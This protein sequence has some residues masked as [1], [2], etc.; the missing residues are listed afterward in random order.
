MVLYANTFFQIISLF[1]ISLIGVMFLVKKK[2]ES[3][4]NHIFKNL[5]I[6]G[7]LSIIL[8]IASIVCAFRDPNAFVSM[9]FGKAYL[10]T[11]IAF[12]LLYSIYAIIVTNG[13]ATNEQK[14]ESYKKHKSLFITIFCLIAVA[15][16]IAPIYTYVDSPKVMYTYGPATILT[17]IIVG[18]NIVLW[19]SLLI[20]RFRKIAPRKTFP[21]VQV[22]VLGGISTLVQLSHPEILLL[23]AAMVFSIVIMYFSVFTIENPDLE[24]I[25]EI[26]NARNAAVKASQAKTDFLS[27]MSHELRTPLNAI[28]GFSQGLMEQDLPKDAEEDVEDIINASESLLELVNE[29]LDISK[30][31]SNKFELVNVDY[32]VRKAYKYL[33]TMTEGRI[34]DKEIEFIHK[35]DESIPPVLY[36]DCVRI[37]QIAINLLTNSVKYTKAGYVKLNMN[38]EKIDDVS[39]YLVVTVSDSGIGIKEEDM[40][41]LF[42]KFSRLDTKKNINIEGTGLGLAL[43]KRM[44]DLMEGE[45]KV[46]SKYGVGSTFTVKIKQNISETQLS[47]LEDEDDLTE[48]QFV[49]HGERIL[50]VDDNKVNLKVVSRL[51]KKYNVNLDFATSGREC[52]EKV[53]NGNNADYDLIMLDDQM[54]GMTGKEVIKHLK[55]IS[56]FHI[57]T[58]ALTA[59]AISGMKEKYLQIGFDGYLSK[60]ID[61]NLLEE[62]LIRFFGKDEVPPEEITNIEET[63][64]IDYRDQVENIMN[65]IIIEDDDPT[66][67]VEQ[68]KEELKEKINTLDVDNEEEA[69]IKEK[70]TE[71]MDSIKIVDEDPTDDVDQYK[72]ELKKQMDTI[73]VEDEE[74]IIPEEVEPEVELLDD[75]DTF[76][77]PDEEDKKGNVEYLKENGID[78]DAAIEALGGIDVYNETARD[79]LDEMDN[80]MADLEKNLENNDLEDYHVVAHALKSD[81]KYM[82]MNNLS[83]LAYNHELAGKEENIEYIQEHYGELMEE[84]N[85]MR[86]VLKK[87]LGR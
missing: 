85:N 2:L 8:D 71:I 49:G 53:V 65:T 40:Q 60:P 44:V 30:I 26:K 70:L 42:S 66:D 81:A 82:G 17:Y 57:P 76:N 77:D 39:G 10:L 80:K 79:V 4:E 87:Y 20:V 67:D 73:V 84:T 16:M 54:P 72:D 45:I 34:G 48:G 69:K 11:I 18:I 41:N 33:V 55:N 1:Y 7:F 83:N 68:F 61:R 46:E 29:I 59:N 56:D 13:K 51:L 47:Q 3:A 52:I 9:L 74:E 12:C 23:T 35:Y 64:E 5:L 31:E 25:E 62:T 50:V 38:Y 14:L 58:I 28:L 43:T 32:D 78:V 19:I 75:E 24:M 22:M 86:E 15:I 21:I 6:V 36:G 37:K 63:K 27:N